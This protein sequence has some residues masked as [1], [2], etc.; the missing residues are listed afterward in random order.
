ME[1]RYRVLCTCLPWVKLA[2][3]ANTYRSKLIDINNGRPLNLRLHL[4]AYISQ[5]MNGWT[6]RET[7]EMVRLHAGVRFLCGIEGSS[8]EIDHSSIVTFRNT[9]GKDGA[10]ELNKIIVQHATEMGFSGSG[11]CSSDTTVQEAPIAYP[12]EV[13]HLKNIAET[14]LGIGKKIKKGIT[15]AMEKLYQKS[16]KIF[17]EIRLFTKGKKEE[18]LEKKKALSGELRKETKRMLLLIKGTLKTSSTKTQEKHQEQIDLCEKMICQIKQWMETGFHPK[19][20]VLSLWHQTAR[21]ISKGKIG[22]SVEFGRRWIVSVLEGGYIIGQ[23]CQKIGADT[24][25][26]IAEEVLIQFLETFGEVPKSFVYDRGGDGK[27]NHEFLE[28]LGVEN[29]CIFLKGNKKMDVSKKFYQEVKRERA[30]SEAAIAVLKSGRYNFNKPR[31]R[32]EDSCITKGQMAMVGANMNRFF[33]DLRESMGLKIE[34][35]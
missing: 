15:S 24:D 30:L 28:N 18:V 21:A 17:R 9:L 29:N 11:I 31:A 8:E 32:S 27:K 1:N 12:T 19:D 35:A 23:P 33:R 2:E 5:S 26:N 10:E 14:L 4:G 34:M 7:E 6:D 20:K 22:K 13:G 25:A 16:Y 3:V